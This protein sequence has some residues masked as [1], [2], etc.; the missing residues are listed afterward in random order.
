LD[1]GRE[2]A[3]KGEAIWGWVVKVVLAR[4]RHSLVHTLSSEQANLAFPPIPVRPPI[5][6]MDSMRD[7]IRQLQQLTAMLVER[8]ERFDGWAEAVGGIDFGVEHFDRQMWVLGL[9]LG[10][11]NVFLMI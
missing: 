10:Y 5:G 3:E 1:L 7:A 4:S 6:Q 9:E 11:I 8:S 2:G